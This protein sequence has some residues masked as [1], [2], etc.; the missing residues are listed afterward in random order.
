MPDKIIVGI[1]SIVDQ[2]NVLSGWALAILGGSILI[3]V[4][5]SYIRPADKKI[6]L[7]YLLFIPG[8]FFLA[9]SMYFGDSIS[10]QYI[11]AVFTPDEQTLLTIGSNINREFA[12]QLNNFGLGITVFVVWLAVYLCWWIFG[13]WII[14]PS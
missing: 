4:S 14:K 9:Y 7:I 1:K 10:R 6:R 8:W 13:N 12:R 2:S 11:A 5:T 3:L